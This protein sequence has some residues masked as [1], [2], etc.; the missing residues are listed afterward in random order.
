MYPVTVISQNGCHPERVR[1]H[2]IGYGSQYDEWRDQDDIIPIQ[3]F[4]S[5]KFDL[6]QELAVKIKSSLLG[7]RK[8][9]PVIRL[10]MPFDLMTFNEGLR[11]SGHAVRTARKV[12]YFKIRRYEE[13]N[14]VLGPNW[15]FREIDAVGD[16]SYAV[17][18]S[19]EYYLYQRRGIAHYIPDDD[20]KPLK[21]VIPCGYMLSFKFV[22]G[23]GTSS[24]FGTNTDIFSQHNI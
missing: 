9:S 8:C 22:R 21:T 5:E 3:C 23:D 2:Y 15:H 12:I 6:N 24:D 14:P 17:L 16:Y 1:I 11:I 7:N 20:Y 19:G 13:L 10:A 18:D 4:N